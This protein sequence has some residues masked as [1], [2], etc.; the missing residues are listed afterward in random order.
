MFENSNF[1]KAKAL[2][3]IVAD[4]MKGTIHMR[5]MGRRY[6]PP[7]AHEDSGDYYSRLNRATL[8]PILSETINTVVGRI[9]SSDMAI[10]SPLQ[11]DSAT[12]NN[13]SFAVM[14]KSVVF[15]AVKFGCGYVFVNFACG[16]PQFEHIPYEA[17]KDV[18]E[19]F[20]GK[21]ELITYRKAGKD[22][23]IGKGYVLVDKQKTHIIKLGSPIDFCPVVAVNINPLTPSV[24][25]APYAELAALCVKL[26][27][28]DSAQDNI[29]SYLRQPLLLATGIGNADNIEVGANMLIVPKDSDV[30][31]V[32]HSGNAVEVGF[33]HID[34]IKQDCILA[35]ASISSLSKIAM[36]DE[37]AEEEKVKTTAR[38]LAW[39]EVIEDSAA[40]MLQMAADY[41]GINDGGKISLR[42][43]ILN[44]KE[45][46]SLD[47]IVSLLQ[48]QV[49]SV[50]EARDFLKERKVING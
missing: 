20:D 32:E 9:F 5:T 31:Y 46:I 42:D 14:L 44:R 40:I 19:D 17:I 22:I 30:R 38:V 35:G 28:A 3:G 29:V 24:G 18:K 26:W 25:I 4:V 1:A 2:N 11:L 37:Q 50:D 23:E 39:C 41:I 10:N 8:T 45:K 7:F 27:Q 12:S 36:T 48:N 6:L 49:I 47:E 43:N 16:L 33:T 13:E 21:I 34:R 15:D